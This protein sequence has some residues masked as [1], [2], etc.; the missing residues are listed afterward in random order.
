[1]LAL[2]L[3]LQGEAE[4]ADYCAAVAQD[5]RSAMYRRS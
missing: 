2:A 4:A 5:E 1:M 3:Y